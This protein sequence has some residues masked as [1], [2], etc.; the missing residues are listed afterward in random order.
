MAKKVFVSGCYDLLH[1]GHIAFFREAAQ[2]GE[3]YVA[4][5]SDKTV[6]DLKGRTPLNS[7]SERLFLVQAVSYVKQAFISSG[8]GMLDFEKELTE[9]HPD[10][11]IVNEDG[12]IPQKRTLCERL[13]IEYKVLRRTPYG[14]LAAR[15]TTAL[16]GINLMP[17]RVDLA[18]GWL[19][20]PFVS[21][22][23]PGV[24][25]TASLEPTIEFNE[26]SGMATST[27]RAAVD[28]WGT[29]LPTGNYEKLAK[30]LFAYDNPPGK[31][32]ISGSQDS[33]GIVYPALACAHYNG[34]YWPSHIEHVRDEAVV[35][36][37][38][39][40][41]YLIPIAP[42][43]EGYNPLTVQNVTAEGARALAEAADAAWRAILARDVQALGSAVR[44]SFEAQ[45]SMFPN[46]ANDFINSLI[47]EYRD[48]ALG[49]KLSGAG[50]GGYLTLITTQP[51]ENAVRV[52][53]RRDGE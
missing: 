11:F 12:N 51:I 21:Q 19:D 20:Q 31:T 32:V 1:S 44:A 30:I 33:I 42:R 34:A 37:V 28:M 38:E 18:G 48:R 43:D 8:S 24:V 49:W 3:L 17:Y 36:F 22:H 4:I 40:S 2:Y 16:R 13:G 35:Q 52:L 29:R 39:Q 5:G 14:E 47:D 41:L 45:I 53:I 26:R 25:I 46:M 7:E 6:F 27:R 9:I 23:H 15:S 10:L 50:G